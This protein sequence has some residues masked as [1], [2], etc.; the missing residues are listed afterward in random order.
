MDKKYLRKIIQSAVKKALNEAKEEQSLYESSMKRVMN[1]IQNYECATLSAWRNQYTDITDNTFK[2]SH[3]YHDKNVVDGKKVGRGNKHI[4]SPMKNGEYFST[5]EKKYYNR[6][7]KAA[8]LKLGYGV[9]NIRGSYKEFGKN[10]SQEESFLIVNLNNDPNFKDKI[11]K[12]SEYYN[13]DSFMYS[14]KGSEEG[15]LIGTNNADFP[16]YGECIP[17]GKFHKD[18][19]SLFMSRIGN[20][21]F[22]FTNGN[23]IDKNDPN[24]EE[25]LSDDSMNNYETDEPL[26]F[27]DRKAKRLTE[28]VDNILQLETYDKYSINGKRA[29]GLYSPNLHL[30]LN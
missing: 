30:I 27:A 6:E 16:G 29:I 1:F 23:E 8:L 17:S 10:E 24:R 13:Q 26:T 28:D 4:G 25:K 2:P 9:T 14:P 12:L 21:G 5:E 3:I 11:F 15:Y 19:Q 22:S 20:K 18:V 7:L